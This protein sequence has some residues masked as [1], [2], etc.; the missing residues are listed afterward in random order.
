MV[1]LPLMHKL[2]TSSPCPTS[3]TTGKISNCEGDRF[4]TYWIIWRRKSSAAQPVVH[5]HQVSLAYIGLMYIKQ[6]PRYCSPRSWQHYRV[7]CTRNGDSTVGYL[8]TVSVF[9]AFSHLL[10]TCVRSRSHRR[11]ELA[12]IDHGSPAQEKSA[13]AMKVPSWWC[14]RW[15]CPTRCMEE[16]EDNK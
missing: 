15:T 10:C 2:F 7:N 14:D 13:V 4:F 3:V 9:V 5:C 11:D 12:A 16:R 6:E 8:T 1:W